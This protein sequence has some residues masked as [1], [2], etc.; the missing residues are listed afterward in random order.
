[1]CTRVENNEFKSKL[2]ILLIKSTIFANS[3]I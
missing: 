3:L 2:R 1:M